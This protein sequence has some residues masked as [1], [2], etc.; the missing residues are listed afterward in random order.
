MKAF[1][2]SL[3][4]KAKKHYWPDMSATKSN[5]KKAICSKALW[6]CFPKNW[7][8]QV[9]VMRQELYKTEEVMRPKLL[10]S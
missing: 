2:R 9:F 10:E 5:V 3:F 8:K 4:L 1:F 7:E 6:F